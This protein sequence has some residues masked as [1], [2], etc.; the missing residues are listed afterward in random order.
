MGTP[1]PQYPAPHRRTSQT[2]REHDRRAFPT[3]A[4][5]FGDICGF[6]ELSARRSAKELI[7]MLNGVFTAFDQL[8]EIRDVEKIKTIGD[9]YLAV[10]GLPTPRAD[11]AIAIAEL[12]IDMLTAIDT[13]NRQHG[14]DLQ[15]RIGI[16]SGPVVAG[17]I[18]KNKFIYDLWGDTV[19]TASRMES[20]GVPGRI[21]VS[22]ASYELLRERFQFEDRGDISVKGKG[23]MHTYFLIPACPNG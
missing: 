7:D 12:A 19:N 10:A 20:H 17:V 23:T 9:A 3:R 2:R 21:H 1:A 18:G 5:L 4:S 8:T 6:T 22:P 14:L 16:H 15:M 11:H 13:I